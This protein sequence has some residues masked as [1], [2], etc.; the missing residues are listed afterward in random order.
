MKTSAAALKASIITYC[1][2]IGANPLLVQG[3]GGNVSWKDDDTLW[4]KASGTWLA[5]A[6][7]KDIF[8]PVDLPQLRSAIDNGQFDVVPIVTG[9][10]SLRPSIE[11]LLHALMPHR[12][13]VHLHAIEVLARL[14]RV[15]WRDDISALLGDTFNWASVPYKKP[16]A[17][18]ARAVGAALASNPRAQVIFLES[19]GVVIG[20][21]TIDD[22]AAIIDTLTRI[23]RSE[24]A[25]DTIMN[26]VPATLSLGEELYLAM[27]D[28][29]LHRLAT[30]QR[31][32]G[33]LSKAWVLYPDH[34]VFLGAKAHIYPDLATLREKCV[35]GAKL[36]EL[37]FIK[38]L[39]V[40]AK[41]DFNIAKQLQLRCY[42]DVVA[43]QD[44]KVELNTLNEM[45][46]GEL[47]NWDAEQYRM[48]L[49]KF[50]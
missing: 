43:R 11:T 15:N 33:Y 50:L 23:L 38:D 3:A 13:V 18:L 24:T 32:F 31:L 30:D 28:A 9:T 26:A 1:A 48:N 35:S 45:Q 12:I 41:K 46:V 5:Q 22:I 36:P 20:G 21:S 16:G 7:E 39:G 2:T 37:I 17:E 25:N 47:L 29:E 4:I 49:A 44:E 10:S 19:H 34:V 27:E 42:L 6:A 40:F 14:V 8:V